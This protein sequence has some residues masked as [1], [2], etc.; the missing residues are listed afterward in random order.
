MTEPEPGRVAW[1][2]L[3]NGWGYNWYR[4]DNQ[5]RADDLL[6][7]GR[8]CDSLHRAAASLRDLEARH[9]GAYL[10]PP[11]RGAPDPDPAR[12]TELRAIRVARAAIEAAETRV[13]SSAAPTDDRIWQRHR[14][15]AATLALLV[16]ADTALI[17]S[18]SALETA[19]SATPAPPA[20]LDLD[21]VTAALARL[22]VVLRERQRLLD[23]PAPG[24]AG[25][26]FDV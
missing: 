6:I 24:E 2:M 10:P 11:R 5:V 16:E 19:A 8:A 17:R 21:G 22:L 18:A 14:D 1:D 9:G 23:F 12:M 26:R 13:R 25:A 20:R 15:N 7:R 4:R 3:L